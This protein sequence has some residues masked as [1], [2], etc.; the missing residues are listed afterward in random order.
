MK[1][2]LHTP[3]A[4]FATVLI[5]I[6]GCSKNNNDIEEEVDN[7]VVIPNGVYNGYFYKPGMD[8]A[9]ITITVNNGNFTGSSNAS[10]PI[11]C[12]SSF[13]N[14]SHRISITNSC[15]NNQTMVPILKG[16]YEY[17]FVRNLTFKMWRSVNNNITEEYVVIRQN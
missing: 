8:T 6:S 2:L 13:V 15:D 12:N 11:I 17:F 9:L 7:S 16:E 14:A 1:K 5:L 4:L 10:Y 3:L